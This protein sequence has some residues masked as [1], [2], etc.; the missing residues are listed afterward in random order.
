MKRKTNFMNH[1]VL[2][3]ESPNKVVKIR[4]FL[5]DAG[6]DIDVLATAGHF[7][8]VVGMDNY[9]PCL[10]LTEGG[11]RF[12]KQLAKYQR[13]FVGTDSDREGEGIG[14]HVRQYAPGGCEL[15]RVRFNEITKDAI[16]EALKA[17]GEFDEDL[18]RQ[19]EFRRLADMIIGFGYTGLLWKAT[20]FHKGSLGR[21]QTPVLRIVM[22]RSM[23]KRNFVS[24]SY[25]S[26]ELVSDGFQAVCSLPDSSLE[27]AEDDQLRLVSMEEATRIKDHLN[28]VGFELV[29]DETTDELERIPYFHTNS[30]L[31]Y[32]SKCGVKAKDTTTALQ[33]LYEDGHLTYIR[34]D[35]TT[36]SDEGYKIVCDYVERDGVAEPYADKPV[37]STSDSAQEAHECIRPVKM[38]TGTELQLTGKLL[39]VYE[40]IFQR[41]LQAS[42]GL[43]FRRRK[44]TVCSSELYKCKLISCDFTLS[45]VGSGGWGYFSPRKDWSNA[46][47]LDSIYNGSSL[48]LHAVV[49]SKATKAPGDYTEGSLIKAMQRMGI[50]RPATY[51]SS[52]ERL[53]DHGYLENGTGKNKKK[54]LITKSGIEAL[55]HAKYEVFRIEYTRELEQRLDTLSSTTPPDL[56]RELER[57]LE[58]AETTVEPARACSCGSYMRVVD[59]KKGLFWGCINRACS[60]TAPFGKRKGLNK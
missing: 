21:V 7:C 22:A 28:R 24:S 13:V 16:V 47:L 11:E 55:K 54:V 32:M 44:L 6:L 38:V 26:V 36:I 10:K 58:S 3:V 25:Y 45:E 31:Q 49:V 52:I 18:I 50:G 12:V 8:E 56:L 48:L 33:K 37:Y 1:S 34:T 9:K 43:R 42:T 53:Y 4:G 5:L 59:G 27:I 17:P 41:T 57:D 39:A 46:G 2:V 19:Q 23:K 29:S 60:S 30:V 40:A 35:S 51:A 14:D 20:G 15:V